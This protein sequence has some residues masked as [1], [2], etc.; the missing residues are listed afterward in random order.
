MA[1]R[2]LEASMDGLRD[3]ILILGGAAEAA[4]S[5]AMR[6][7]VQ[8]DPILA[9]EVIDGDDVVD[10][11]ELEI[12]QFCLDII[13]LKTPAARDL[14]FVLMSAK[15]APILE[16]MADLASNIARR[17]L[18]LL[19]EP[20]LKPY[21]DLPRM[22]EIAL[23]MLSGALEAYAT[24]DSQKAREVIQEDNEIDNLYA[25][26][27]RELFTF[28]AEDPKTITRVTQLLFIAK[29]LERIGDQV[30]NICEMVVYVKEARV[31][32][33]E[34]ALGGPLPEA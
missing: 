3:K 31:I 13:A 15:I 8:R 22:A 32:K 30:T 5:R 26:V 27:F 25:Q 6:A 18:L 19:E 21:I 2:I 11:M 9:Q 7:L 24:T 16:R 17:S 34:H 10:R 12:D 1:N 33:H 20:Q 23:H 4:I 29:H 14:R 28:M